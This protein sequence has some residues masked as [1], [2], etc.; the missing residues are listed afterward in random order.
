MDIKFE[1]TYHIVDSSTVLG[2]L[3]KADAKLKPFEG[4]RVAEVQT[5]G[6]FIDGWLENWYWVD[7]E[8][9]PADWATKPRVVS[10]L[11][12]DG[13]WQRGPKFLREDFSS[14]P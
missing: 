11:A 9:N 5:A 6:R 12:A 4:V 3:H 10:D 1:N 2:Y 8:L 14:W 13:F 7:G